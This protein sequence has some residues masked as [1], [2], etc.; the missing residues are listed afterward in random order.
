MTTYVALFRGINVG[1]NNILPMKVLS[2]LLERIGLE[3]VMT[4]IQSGNVVFKT[5]TSN[6][7]SLERR[8][9]EA[10]KTDCG[11]EPWVLLIEKKDFER[12]IDANP[13]PQAT[14]EPKSL[15]F[16]F[17][18]EI[19]NAPDI[20]G[21]DALRSKTENFLIVGPVLYLHAPDGVGRSKLAAKI[22]RLLGV[23]TT[24]RNWRTVSKI[25]E[26]ARIAE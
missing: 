11:F 7:V 15:H 9:T 14:T 25:A 20:A 21:L 19:P 6:T 5:N 2:A 22:E 4:Y 8:I 26:L 18:S 1:G 3:E 10:V 17:L 23:P 12:A 13:F 16:F 24:A